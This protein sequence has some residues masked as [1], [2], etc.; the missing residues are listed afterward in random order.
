[1]A[2]V[3]EFSILSKDKYSKQFA[4]FR[5][6][7]NQLTKVA[8]GFGGVVAGAAGVAAKA[9]IKVG[10]TTET[11]KLRMDAMLRSVAE[12][13]QV[14]KDM[15]QFAS[16]VPFAYE[17]IMGAATQLSGILKGGAEEIKQTMPMIADLAAVSGLSIEKTTEQ[18]TRLFS[19]G[20]G[21][22]DLFRERGINAMLGF[23]AGVAATA[24]ESKKKLIEAFESSTSKFR[25]AAAKMATTW[26]GVMSMIGDKWFAMKSQINEAGVFNYFKSIAIVINDLMGQA[27][28]NTRENAEVW[29]NSIIGGI[30]AVMKGLGGL[31]DMFRGL[32]VTWK[33]L[34]VAFAGA[35]TVILAALEGINTIIRPIVNG[36]IMLQN[37][38]GGTTI[39]LIGSL[40]STIK[41]SAD[42]TKELANEFTALATVP[43][44]SESIEDFTARV[45]ATYKKLQAASAAARDAQTKD[46]KTVTAVTLE[47]FNKTVEAD[48]EKNNKLLENLITYSESL[49]ETFDLTMASMFQNATTLGEETSAIIRETFD[50]VA[51]GIGEAV[52][53]TILESENLGEAL[54]NVLRSVLNSII[55]TFITMGIKRLVMSAI[56]GKAS[57]KEAASALA[58]G[59]A[60]TYTNAFASTA[61]IPIIGPALA[62]GVAAASLAAVT[63][64][65]GAAGAAGTG[66]GMGIAGI[67]HGGMS[68]VPKEATYLLDEG[69]RVLSPNQNRDLTNFM[70]EGGGGGGTVIE[71]VNVMVQTSASSFD[72]MDE[73]TTVEFVADKVIPALDKLDKQGVRQAALERSNI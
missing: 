8:A 3:V 26:G 38:I 16:E 24:E 34:E 44:P 45:E 13:N 60:Q 17:E 64:G 73:E 65:A 47:Q 51:A 14:F 37:L 9:L 52:A 36:W 6:S 39:P 1:M 69:E 23:E 12:G 58:G 27:L 71:N 29:A 70:D 57:A 63:A 72:T 61:A 15:T 50:S 43:M 19:A 40:N 54:Q 10:N 30:R 67:A 5:T 32:Q 42:R 66:V 7:V 33:G 28:D 68:N 59:F 21:S 22:A 53:N 31:L 11:F 49:T 41:A 2:N 4:S 20:A 25:G 46:Q 62:P 48:R 18:I 56:F 35:A 55:S